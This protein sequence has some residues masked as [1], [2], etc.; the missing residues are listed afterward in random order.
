MHKTQIRGAKSGFI[1]G[2]TGFYYGFADG[3]TG[4]VTTPMR[5]HKKNVSK[6]AEASL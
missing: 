4:L 3:L 1:S 5:G 6:G 2:T